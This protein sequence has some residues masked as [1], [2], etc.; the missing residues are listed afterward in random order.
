M[1]LKILMIDDHPPIIEGYKAILSYNEMGY[2]I[3][4]TAAHNC[5]E[6]YDIITSTSDQNV[7]DLVFIDITLP[8]YPEKNLNSGQD[9]IFFIQKQLPNAK[10]IV[11]TSHTES[12]LLYS[13]IKENK[14]NGLLIKNDISAQ[15]FLV[16]FSTIMNGTTY[17][18]KTVLDLKLES[19]NKTNYLDNYNR[20]IITLLSQGIKTK[21][22]G[23]HLF[24]SNSSIEKRKVV[25]KA[26][27]GIEKGNDEDI[28]R[29]AR[30]KG[31]I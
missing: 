2:K 1:N 25:I 9:L 23:E 17:Y 30:N 14:P 13:I 11:L 6:A 22:L 31:L 20:Q 19:A 4:T 10:I 27:L 29:E 8:L 7:F 3:I 21:N 16:A 12:F 24:L 18:S 5:K 15:E 26:F 28:L